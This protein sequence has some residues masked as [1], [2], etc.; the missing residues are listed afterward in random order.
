MIM[1][2]KERPRISCGST[3]RKRRTY[4]TIQC[5]NATEAKTLVEQGMRFEG[6]IPHFLTGEWLDKMLI[7]E[8]GKEAQEHVPFA[9]LTEN[10]R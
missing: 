6:S 3:W 5:D 7:G 10:V 9:A 4:N 1:K 8:V 2:D